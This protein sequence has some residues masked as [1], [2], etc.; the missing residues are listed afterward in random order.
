[1]R[2]AGLLGALGLLLGLAGVWLTV[3][4]HR[5]APAV[6]VAGAGLLAVGMAGWE[7]GPNG[8]KEVALVAAVGAVAA[9]GR[10][11]FAAIPNVQPVTTMTACAGVALGPRAGAA[12]GAL[13]AI[14]S[15]GFLGQGPWTPWQ[16]L[17]WGLVGT[18]GGLLGPALRRRSALVAYCFACGFAFDALLNVSELATFGPTWSWAAF[19]ALEVRGLGF[20]TAHAVGNALLALVAG[21]ALIRLLDRYG[22]R[23]R[24]DIEWLSG[25]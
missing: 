22:R 1:M 14:L 6:V 10:V 18:G 15:N 11:L 25:A 19:W 12:V 5:T 4:D 9:A 21:P 3:V 16:M 2:P 24:V 7:G 17:A 13:A 23:L 8:A 20:D